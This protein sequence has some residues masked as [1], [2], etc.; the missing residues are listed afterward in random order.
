M[1]ISDLNYLEVVEQT[2]IVGGGGRKKHQLEVK[3]DVKVDVDIKG[4]LA[5][6]KGSAYA[7]GKNTLAQTI[8]YTYT[9]PYS[10]SASAE[11]VSGT[12]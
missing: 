2:N 7:D 4:N 3:K 6:A 8:T 1:I 5:H 11:S 10:S 12:D 9:T